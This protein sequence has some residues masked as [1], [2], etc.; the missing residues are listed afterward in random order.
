MKSFRFLMILAFAAPLAAQPV[1]SAPREGAIID[2]VSVAGTGRV[3]LKPD[4]FSFT[5][6]VQTQ[7]PTVEEAVNENNTRVAAVVAALKK[8]GATPEEIQTSGFSIYPQQDYSQ[9]RLPQLLGY[10]VSNSITVTKKQIG[11]AGKLLQAA[12]AAGVNTSS[13]LT[14]SV[15]DPTRGRDQ[16][17]RAAFD[18]ARAKA[19]LLAGAAGRTLGQALAITEGTEPYAPPRP[20]RGVVQSMAMKAEVSEVPVES[21]TDELTFSVSVIFAL[22]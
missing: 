8:A 1:S 20:M 22:R 9:G 21:G 5:V 18:D 15:S 3:R 2:T 10:Q 17:L 12:I 7:A 4:R 11:D 6:G 14:F 19:T 16:G 13:G